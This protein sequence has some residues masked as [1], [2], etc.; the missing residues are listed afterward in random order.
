MEIK[1]IMTEDF[2]NCFVC[3]KPAQ[4]WHHVM[5]KADKKKSEKYGLLIPVCAKCHSRIHD[6]DEEL[7]KQIKK[8]AQADFMME[9]SF[10]LWMKEFG[11]NYI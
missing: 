8:I 7:N 5:N 2:E 3:G 10:G 11:K 9:H 6:T 4:Q 1:S